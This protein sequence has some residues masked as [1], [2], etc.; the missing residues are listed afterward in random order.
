[1]TLKPGDPDLLD[2]DPP[3]NAL[4]FKMSKQENLFMA[5]LIIGFNNFTIYIERIIS[6]QGNRKRKQIF[7]I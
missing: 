2:I 3:E 5:L 6:K 4:E 7:I 1:M